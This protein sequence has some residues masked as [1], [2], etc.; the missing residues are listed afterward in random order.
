MIEPNEGATSNDSACC[1]GGSCA[2]PKPNP[3]GLDRREFLGRIGAGAAAIFLP[4]PA[5]RPIAGPFEIDATQDA[6]PVP[7]DKKL[8]PAWLKSLRERG[9]PTIAQKSKGELR[10]IGMPIGGIGNG[11][12]YIGGDGRLWHWD[13]FN[14]PADAAWRDSSGGHYARPA[15]ID[16]KFDQGFGLHLSWTPPGASAAIEKRI[17]LDARDW[18]EITFRG[19]YPI[20]EVIYEDPEMPVRVELEAFSP[21]CPL[22][23]DDSGIPGVVF[24]FRIVNLR[25][26]PVT[27]TM[28]GWCEL[29][30]ATG[31]DRLGH[32][33]TTF[34]VRHG[35]DRGEVVLG[36]ISDDDSPEPQSGDPREPD[37]VFDDFESGDYAAWSVDGEAFGSA[38]RERS[39]IPA[40]QGD[41]GGSGKFVVNSHFP[42]AGEDVAAGD[43]KRGRL[44][45]R[46]FRIQRNFIGFFIGGGAHP[47]KTGI[48]LVVDGE[49]VRRATGRNDNKML[50]ECFDVRSL[51]GRS[52]TIEIVD[53]V[54]GG[55]GN[56]GVDRI[57]FS[58]TPRRDPGRGRGVQEG[59]ITLSARGAFGSVFMRSIDTLDDFVPLDGTSRPK[60]GRLS[61]IGRAVKLEPLAAADV[62]FS[63]AWA[64]AG[65]ASGGLESIRGI[66]KL[67]RRS[68]AR[69]KDSENVA[70]YLHKNWDRLGSTTRAWRDTFY[71]RSTLPH[72]FLERTFVNTSTL[73]TATCLWLSNDRFW[74]WEGTYCCPGTCTHVWQYAQAVARIFPN[75][76]RKT[77]EMT[78]F[79]ASFDDAT[80]RIDYRSEAS[81]ELA[82]DGQCGTILR[83]WREH[84]MSADDGF[85]RRIWPRVK[86]AIELLIARDPDRNGI[87]D[88]AQYNT[89]DTA[90]YGKIAWIS[91]LYLA[92]LRA[93]EEMAKVVG[94]LLFAA[95]AREIAAAGARSMVAE[96]FDGEYFIHVP[97]PKRPDANSTGKGCHIDQVF[98][99]SYAHQLGLGRI[100]PE[101]E[102]KSALSS[103]YRYS[104][105]PDVGKYRE[106]AEKSIKGGRWYAMPGEGGLL[107]C[108]WPKGGIDAATGKSGDAWAAG[109]FNECMTGFE[110]QVASHMMWEGMVE[111]SLVLTRTIHDRYHASRRNPFNEVE[112]SDHYARAMASYGT[113][114]AACGFV[115]D[116][117]R[118]HIGFAPRISPE[119]FAAAF[120]GAEGWG[121]LTMKQS[122]TRVEAAIEIVR[123]R[124]RLRSIEIGSLPDMARWK[125]ILTVREIRSGRAE[126]RPIGAATVVSAGRAELLLESEIVLS[127]NESLAIQFSV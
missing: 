77:R 32:G 80:G 68:F 5:R 46:E 123:G 97:D 10:Y 21:F 109:Y 34:S 16:K 9:A 118:G 61:A 116:G 58:N 127:E 35:A 84:L 106:I 91:S 86:K 36:R 40:Y 73:A 62:E 75:L 14:E 22:N 70:A 20:A 29:P 94:D 64:F 11:Q 120:T 17:Y 108:A 83:A 72:W 93:G 7:A 33:A 99:Q 19:R 3:H 110:H 65:L 56:V 2:G 45:S 126:E 1:G 66:E 57:V 41:V 82:V 6:H 115:Y 50:R 55:W 112:C 111:E 76:E 113:Y 114:L 105:A 54:G 15:E 24:R 101:K 18:R 102:T 28:L 51:R 74:A 8:D 26:F 27:A 42:R 87:L 38:P 4:F 79:G 12:L 25:E 69:W 107:M 47:E 81:R 52:A 88:G 89:L 49:I 53:E 117:P 98:G 67:E 96:V 23:E 31:H 95:T 122:P 39:A 85:L 119:D 13:I 104:F 125:A 30:E 44:K 71:D 121:R 90:W 48:H 43:Q 59:S 63:L 37:I 103:L 100:L 92:A 60:V 124:L 78:D